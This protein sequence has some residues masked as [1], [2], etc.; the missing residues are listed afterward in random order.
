VPIQ[1]LPW[2]ISGLSPNAPGSAVVGSAIGGL[3]EFSKAE[4]Q[5]SIRGATGDTLNLI[6]QTSFDGKPVSD[7]SKT[8]WDLAAYVQLAAGSGPFSTLVSV[9]RGS[10][11][12]APQALTQGTL[13][14]GTVLQNALGD[15]L[16][17]LAVPGAATTLGA[18][19]TLNIEMVRSP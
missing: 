10:T 9:I 2:T 8:W 16:R 13:A 19:Q 4:I 11:G 18:L 3:Q 1:F 5:A 17:L 12:A 6:V 14:A 15:A 7:P